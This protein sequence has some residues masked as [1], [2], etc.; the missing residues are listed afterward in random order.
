MVFDVLNKKSQQSIYDWIKEVKEKNNEEI[1]IYILVNKIDLNPD[2][3][4]DEEVNAFITKNKYKLFYTS[5]KENKGINEMF[6]ELLV[7]YENLEILN[8]NN[9]KKRETVLQKKD[10]NRKKKRKCCRS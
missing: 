9:I 6:E 4:V 1:L 8:D 3:K 10:I 2:F 5:A 7:D